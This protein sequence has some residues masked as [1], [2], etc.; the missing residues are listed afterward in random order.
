MNNPETDLEAVRIEYR[1]QLSELTFN[2]K[3]IITNLTIIAQENVHV[4]RAIV[5]AIEDQIKGSPPPQKLPVLYLLDSIS[6]N[7]GGTYIQLFSHNLLHTFIDAYNVVD[8]ATKQKF[9]RVLAT[10]KV[11]PNGGPVY[12]PDVTGSIERAV[13]KQQ[14]R[15]QSRGSIDSGRTHIHINPN[16]LAGM[17]S[18]SEYQHQSQPQQQ[19]VQSPQQVQQLQNQWP[20]N[21]HYT[22]GGSSFTITPPSRQGYYSTQLYASE[23]PVAHLPLQ[24]PKQV[25]VPPP[26][27]AHLLQEYRSIL[28]QRQQYA[29]QNAGDLNNQNQIQ[30][31]QQLLEVM[32]VTMLTPDQIQQFRQQIATYNMSPSITATRVNLTPAPFTNLPASI[33][34]T[35]IAQ[36]PNTLNAPQTSPYNQSLNMVPPVPPTITSLVSDPNALVRNLM[37]FGL[38]G[39]NPNILNPMAGFNLGNNGNNGVGVVSNTSTPP[40]VD[41][42]AKS[43]H[44]GDI[45]KIEL[46]SSDVQ[47]RREG[48]VSVLYDAY[49]LQCKQCGFRYAKTEE[50]K[51]KM[52]T[53]LDWHFRQNRRMKDK[54]KKAQ[55]RSW[56]VN[57]EDWIYS[58]ET[59]SN[60]SK[61]PAFFDF[62]NISSSKN[63]TNTSQT[64]DEVNESTVIVPLDWEKI[65]KPCPICQEKFKKFYSDPD[66][67]WIFKNA[68]E[69]DSVIYHASCYAD[70]V[71][72]QENAQSSLQSTPNSILGKRKVE[73]SQPENHEIQ[74]RPALVS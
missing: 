59:D 32:Q 52:D 55:S 22:N 68:I 13:V 27:Q 10:W 21:R 64:K 43:S 74:K 16:F 2:S 14:M 23:A 8:D 65:S 24:Q 15:H 47:K 6:K 53:H 5:Q 11:G 3:P 61:T 66:D 25:F 69:V 44:L 58:R 42:P 29:L 9:E 31:L 70:V 33:G 50:G 51:S 4:A 71:K 35:L 49:P 17:T 45:G 39:S 28:L 18:I 37:E 46:T 12:P 38:L 62:D 20:E 36:P 40:T 7:V 63:S 1:A 34:S 48:T 26:D 56:F 72:N 57:E 54:A 30:A 19:A 60:N 73:E 67:E 41:V